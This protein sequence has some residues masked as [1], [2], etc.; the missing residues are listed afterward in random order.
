MTRDELLPIIEKMEQY[1]GS[2]AKSLA[3]ALRV[4]WWWSSTA[5]CN[6]KKT[7][8]SGLRLPSWL[9]AATKGW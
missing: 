8:S 7:A 2:F 1:G 5:V 4:A 9:M 6:G 3:I